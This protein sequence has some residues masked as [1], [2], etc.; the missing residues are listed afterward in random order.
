[1]EG[2]ARMPRTRDTELMRK[3]GAAMGK[4]R[5]QLGWSQQVLA[6]EL[7]ISVVH[8]GLLERGQRL[9]SLAI[10]IAMADVLGLSLDDIFLKKRRGNVKETDEISRLVNALD[11]DLR[12]MAVAFL[13]AGSVASSNAKRRPSGRS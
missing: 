6:E 10:L 5:R 7:D 2:A 13:R 8:A 9:P 3:V 12:P 11:P 4:A 1:M